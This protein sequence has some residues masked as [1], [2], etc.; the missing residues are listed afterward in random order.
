MTHAWTAPWK[1]YI[2]LQWI[3]APQ[4]P[5]WISIHHIPEGTTRGQ[6]RVNRHRGIRMW[7]IWLPSSAARRVVAEGVP[8][9]SGISLHGRLDAATGTE[10]TY[11]ISRSDAAEFVRTMRVAIGVLEWTTPR[12]D[13]SISLSRSDVGQDW[14]LRSTVIRH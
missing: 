11:V 7:S 8:A 6:R 9:E 12:K 14:R 4:E 1:T 13:L 3:D 5:Y 10:G 2:T